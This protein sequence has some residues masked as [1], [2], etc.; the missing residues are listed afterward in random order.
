[1]PDLMRRP[2]GCSTLAQHRDRERSD[3]QEREAVSAAHDRGLVTDR[4]AGGDDRAVH[5][6]RRIG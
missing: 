2:A 6:T 4:L 1:M 3:Q 5:R